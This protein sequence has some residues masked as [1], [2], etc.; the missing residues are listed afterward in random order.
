VRG[1]SLPADRQT[2]NI[3]AGEIARILGA[4]KKALEEAEKMGNEDALPAL[5]G[6]PEAGNA[7]SGVPGPV[8]AAPQTSADKAALCDV[9]LPFLRGLRETVWAITAKNPDAAADPAAVDMA[10]L[11]LT[12]VRRLVRGE[13][14]AAYVAGL[15]IE[16]GPAN[17]FG[18]ALKIAAMET[19]VGL[20]HRRYFGWHPEFGG[21]AWY[22]RGDA[23]SAAAR[24][25]SP[26]ADTIA[27]AAPAQPAEMRELRRSLAQ[28]IAQ[29]GASR[30]RA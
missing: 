15:R 14:M 5:A 13:P 17:R 10:Q 8:F 6:Q 27:G 1:P 21:P 26:R 9:L 29:L 28:R 11:L 22:L 20:F 4:T 18:L 24:H 16:A 30:N 3:P 19:A 25:L 12:D 7:R 23:A 2:R